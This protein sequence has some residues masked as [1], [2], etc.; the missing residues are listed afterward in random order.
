MVETRSP[1]ILGCADGVP[2]R[3]RNRAVSLP[4]W[5]IVLASALAHAFGLWLVPGWRTS[6]GAPAATMPVQLQARLLVIESP[7]TVPAPAPESVPARRDAAS[8]PPTVRQHAAT[9]PVPVEAREKRNPEIL[10]VHRDAPLQRAL[11]PPG[12]GGLSAP[13]VAEPVQGV[14]AGLT[15]IGRA[16][17]GRE[18]LALAATR[19]ELIHHS[20]VAYLH[21]PK[22]AYPAM[23]RK[24]GL[25]GTV[26]L[27]V[28]VNPQGVP[29]QSTIIAT[30]G[31]EVLDTAA[32]DAM[33]HWRFVP[34]RAGGNPIAH[35]VDVPITFK[36]AQR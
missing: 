1:V 27:R 29:E 7:L 34:A 19:A 2:G 30:S 17:Q 6:L 8:R 35:W 26:T 10:T 3:L 22:P 21:N 31:A 36:L 14:D 33:R 9:R 4:V 32:V 12:E 5:A 23:A 13:A 28:L 24:L 15:A 18:V 20:D 16:G 11:T 25:E